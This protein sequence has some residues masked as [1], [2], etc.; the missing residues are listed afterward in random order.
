M[1]GCVT[2]MICSSA[3][4]NIELAKDSFDLLLKEKYSYLSQLCDHMNIGIV[5]FLHTLV[6][7]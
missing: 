7:Q 2:Q 4:V 3:N 6:S 1:G 5:F